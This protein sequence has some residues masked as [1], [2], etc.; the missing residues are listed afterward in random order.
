VAKEKPQKAIL[1]IKR[2][3]FKDKKNMVKVLV[4]GAAGFIGCHLVK[5]LAEENHS[6]VC[7]DN[8]NDY[9][10][11]DLKYGRLASLGFERNAVDAADA[12]YSAV[13]S[14]YPTIRF[15]KT[16]L[17]DTERTAALF[18]DGAFD[19]VLHL[20]AQAG[21]RYS[22]VNPHAYISANIQGFFNVLEAVRLHPPRHLVYASSSSVYGLNTKIPFSENDASDKPA[23]L[24]AATKRSG[25]LMA[26]TYSHLYRIP[27]TGLRFFTVYG[28][29]GRPDMSPFIFTKA[30]SEGRPINVFN[31]GNMKR[32]FTFIDDIVE[33]IIRVM[34]RIPDGNGEESVPAAIYNI[35]NGAPVPLMDFIHTLEDALGKKAVIQYAPMQPGDVCETWADCSALERDTGFHPYT[36]LSDGIHKFIKWY[37]SYY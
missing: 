29:W 18:S 25:E 15:I 32:D 6:V 27:S 10:D 3:Y 34:N 30:I 1:F 33:C 8:I 36:P 17:C 12:D 22:L 35:G 37:N 2:I 21:V 16:D 24:Y 4:T 9:Y 5:R 20:A 7:V 23:S 26:Y 28:P 19:A 14:V 31:N 13:S 11:V